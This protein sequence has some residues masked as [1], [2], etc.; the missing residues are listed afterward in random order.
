VEPDDI[1]IRFLNNDIGSLLHKVYHS[2]VDFNPEYQRGLVWSH[3]Q[4]VALIDSIFQRIDIGKFTF[5]QRDFS[6]KTH[7]FEIIDGKQRLSA[8]CEYYEDRFEWRGKRYSELCPTD[9]NHF[10]TFPI[11]QGEVSQVTP[12]Q[13]L[14]LF[15]KLNTSGTPMDAD[16]LEKVRLM[17]EMEGKAQ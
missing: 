6:D 2:G 4:K 1:R 3:D 12:A 16:H 11:I 8:I 13:I 14:K 7:Y 9:A 15:V 10:D 5:I 17:A